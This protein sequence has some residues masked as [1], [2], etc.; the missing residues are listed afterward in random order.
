M[1]RARFDRRRLFTGG[2]AAPLLLKAQGAT[3]AK[4][5][6]GPKVGCQE[7]P[8]TDEWL[9]FYARL[10]VRNICGVLKENADGKAYSVEQLSALRERCSAQGI[11]LDMMTEPNLRPRPIDETRHPAIMLGQSPERDREIEKVQEL[12]RNCARAGI[13]AIRYNLTIVGYLRSGRVPGPGGATYTVWRLQD[14]TPMRNK[15][16]R[17]GRVSADAFWERITY[18]LDRVIPVANEHRVRMACHPHDPPTPPGFQG[19]DSVLGTVEGL[20]K[21]VGIRESAYHGLNF[22]QGTIAT[23]LAEPAREIFDVIRWFGARKKIFNVH[24]R[25]IRGRRD[26]FEERLPDGGDID[27]VRAMRLYRELGY[28]GMMMPDHVPRSPDDP[29]DRQALAYCYGYIKALLQ[30]TA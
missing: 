24:F 30:A 1:T 15:Q 18:F 27:F 21:F 29:E 14:V 5:S 22:C 13:P 19:V 3:A 4:A 7:G 11:S 9:R 8:T 20:K 10:G 25:N 12:I 28:D 23:M 2:L 6:T 17:A 26:D 16:T